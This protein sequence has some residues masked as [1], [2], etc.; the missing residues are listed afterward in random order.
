MR[1]L[2]LILLVLS[3]LAAFAADPVHLSFVIHGRSPLEPQHAEQAGYGLVETAVFAG[4]PV[5]ATLAAVNLPRE[6]A[7]A[8]A[9]R[10]QWEAVDADGNVIPLAATVDARPAPATA[11]LR[12]GVV[13]VNVTFGDLAPGRYVVRAS[14]V[15][16]ATRQRI[17]AE[18][19]RLSVYR[20]DENTIV[21]RAFLRETA[22]RALAL[23]T[24]D[25][26]ETARALLLQ[27]AAGNPDPLVYESL[28]DA[29]APWASPEE[30]AR[31]YEQSLA[32]AKGN[33]ERRFGQRA[34]WPDKAITL[35]TARESKVEAFSD[36]LPYYRAN[37]DN[38]RVVV[39][40]EGTKDK[41]VIQR[42]SDGARLREIHP[43]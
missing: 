43:Q 33:L 21:E 16:S 10:I 14:W 5:V 23:G 22:R 30:T 38:V 28:A 12:D 11:V 18:G 39:V 4:E 17:T 27:A 29:S 42:R 41:F 34:K 37:F 32:V 8:W 3:G 19:K 20:G 7:G 25:G 31:Y 36:L 1:R 15:D 24:R 13:A 6:G 40:R 9:D 35:F 26:Y 2:L